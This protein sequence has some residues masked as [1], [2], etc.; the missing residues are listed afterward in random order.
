[1]VY[2]TALNSLRRCFE[3]L[4]M[5]RRAKQLP[6]LDAF[7]AERARARSEPQDAPSSEPEGVDD[8]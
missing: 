6:T 8:D 5:S 7:L 4:G 2:Q 3:A 1:L